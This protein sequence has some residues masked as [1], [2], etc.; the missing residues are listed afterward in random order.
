MTP[1]SAGWWII[2][3]QRSEM[4]NEVTSSLSW[5]NTA[6]TLLAGLLSGGVIIKLIDRYLYRHEPRVKVERAAAETRKI[7]V[8]TDIEINKSVARSTVRLER[9]GMQ[10]D[11]MQIRLGQKDI[12][13][14]LA[15][16]DIKKLKSLLDYHGIP[17][18]EFDERKLKSKDKT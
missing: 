6:Y 13:L 3:V 14:Q 1:L 15:Q 4:Q 12:E 16:Q 11:A 8:E 17:F 5:L 2:S 7:H 18:S 10:L 9:M